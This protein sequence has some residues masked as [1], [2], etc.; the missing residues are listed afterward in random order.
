MIRHIL[1]VAMLACCAPAMAQQTEAVSLID[2][3]VGEMGDVS[4]DF[5]GSTLRVTNA[6]GQNLYVYSVTGM[7]VMSVKVDGADKSY[8]LNLKRGCYIVKVGNVV[9]KISVR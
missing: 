3:A 6:A 4:I 7:R 8:N 9:R 5:D 1:F 2:V